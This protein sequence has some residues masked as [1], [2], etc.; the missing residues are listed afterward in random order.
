MVPHPMQ[1]AEAEVSALQML[2]V[3]RERQIQSQTAQCD[4]WELR[5]EPQLGSWRSEVE[6]RVEGQIS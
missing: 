2:R 3:L 6:C 5:R 1:D 4:Q